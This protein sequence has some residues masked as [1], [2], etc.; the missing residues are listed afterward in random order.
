MSAGKGEEGRMNGGVQLCKLQFYHRLTHQQ[1][2][3]VEV[4]VEGGMWLVVD[5]SVE[6]WM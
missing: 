3:M 5:V 6:G 1:S 2:V 4:L